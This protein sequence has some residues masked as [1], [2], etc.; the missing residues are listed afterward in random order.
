MS[1]Y[2]PI[3]Q[4]YLTRTAKRRCHTQLLEKGT[5]EPSVSHANVPEV[6]LNEQTTDAAVALMQMAIEGRV[7]FVF[8]R[9]YLS[10]AVLLLQ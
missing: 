10:S 2:F 6:L 5:G 4:S 8:M 1:E 3:S 7:V 9:K